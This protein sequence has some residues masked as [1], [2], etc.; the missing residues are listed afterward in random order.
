[1][2][3]KNNSDIKILRW[4]LAL[5][6]DSHLPFPPY[7]SSL[8]TFIY[9]CYVFYFLLRLTFQFPPSI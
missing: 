1:M 5:S 2:L 9:V 7:T 8:V 3:T 6:T 4:R